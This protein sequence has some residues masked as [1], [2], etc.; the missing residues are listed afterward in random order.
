MNCH[1]Q[2]QLQTKLE[3]IGDDL[4]KTKVLVLCMVLMLVFSAVGMAHWSGSQTITIERS[5]KEFEYYLT[6]TINYEAQEWL[7]FTGV[8][9]KHIGGGLDGD[10]SV[11][12]YV[13]FWKVIYLTGGVYKGLYKSDTPLTPYFQATL[14]F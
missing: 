1:T 12:V 13:P 8:L 11:T 6:T 5:D 4:L 3:E 10:L 14:Q 2:K 7:H 9:E